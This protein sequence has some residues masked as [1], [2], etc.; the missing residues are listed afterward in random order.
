[1]ILDVHLA[2]LYGVPVKRLNEQVK[3]NQARFPAD[4]V[5]RITK[6]E[7][8]GLRSQIATSKNR[9][10]RRYLPYA[11]TE[12]GTI[13]AATVPNSERAI[14]V[15]VF[16]VRAFMRLRELMASDR[17]LAAKINELESRVGGHDSAIR[18]LVG[19]IKEMMIPQKTRDRRIGFELP[20]GQKQSANPTPPGGDAAKARK[21]AA[22]SCGGLS[23]FFAGRRSR[24]NSRGKGKRREPGAGGFGGFSFHPH[25]HLWYG[26]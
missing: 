14:H 9:G 8:K 13:M 19:A 21:F 5:L 7:D 15:S 12:H 16:V 1:V 20:P 4:F 24:E 10:G 11:F 18:T 26:Y 22:H 2:E 25:G 23:F 17:R 6:A 3:R